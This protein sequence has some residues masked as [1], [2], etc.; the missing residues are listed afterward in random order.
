MTVDLALNL[1]KLGNV[2]DEYRHH[3][4]LVVPGDPIVTDNLIL[5]WYEISLP[6]HPAP[7]RVLDAAR[8]MVRESIEN[9][10]TPSGH[11]FG[12]AIL[13]QSTALT[14]VIIGVW[15]ANQELWTAHFTRES[16]DID[17]TFERVI[18]GVD[19]STLCVWELAPVWHDR[20]AWV[21][22]LFSD[23]TEVN[24]RLYLMDRLSGSV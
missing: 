24:K 23:R 12:L 19:G 16:A 4:R 13:H 8:A 15:T 22:Y 3:R 2:P 21:R 14:Y 5:K 18:P 7:E 20:Q 1:E 9:G 17:G 11:G 10:S 6:D